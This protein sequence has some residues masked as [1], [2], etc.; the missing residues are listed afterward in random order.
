MNVQ[1]PLNIWS[2]A[3]QDA[4]SCVKRTCEWLDRFFYL[5]TGFFYVALCRGASLPPPPT[6]NSA[7]CLIALA[8]HRARV[9][10]QE[11]AIHGAALPLFRSVE[12]MRSA[13]QSTSPGNLLPLNSFGFLPT[14]STSYLAELLPTCYLNDV[15]SLGA[16][17]AYLI[18]IRRLLC[19]LVEQANSAIDSPPIHAFLLLHIHRALV[20]AHNLL[21]KIP[22]ALDGI[23]DADKL[24]DRL[25]T[26]IQP[27]K[28]DALRSEFDRLVRGNIQPQLNNDLL[29][30]VRECLT[31]SERLA[32]TAVLT[33]LARFKR[34]G[35]HLSDPAALAFG[36]MVIAEG[37]NEQDRDV[38]D[39]GIA[40]L[41]AM[42]SNGL[43]APGRPFYSDEKGRALLVPSM[44]TSSALISIC[45]ESNLS[46]S[47]DVLEQVAK[48]T[49]ETQRHLIRE[50]NRVRVGATE[51]EGWCSDRAITPD[52]VESW[53]TAGAL[54]FFVNRVRLLR[55]LKRRRVFAQYISEAQESVKPRWDK[56][57]DPDEGHCTST[58][59]LKIETVLSERNDGVAPVF[60]LYGPP[61]TSK[62]TVA[63]SAATKVGWDLLL[64]SPSD[65]VSD[66][67]DLMEQHS[68]RVFDD[69]MNVDSCVIVFDEVDI[70]FRD[71]QVLRTRLPGSILE[72]VVPALL[73]KLQ[74]FRDYSVSRNV[75]IFFLT[76]YFEMIDP[77]ISRGGRID[78]KIIVLPYSRPARK[79]IAE[80][81]YKEAR[82]RLDVKGAGEFDKLSKI[83]DD[84]PCNLGY[85]DIE[86]LVRSAAKSGVNADAIHQRAAE[87][88]VRPEAYKVVDRIGA[89][90]EFCQFF[91]RLVSEPIAAAD[92][93]NKDALI[94]LLKRG[95]R[96]V[97]GRELFDEWSKL[98]EEWE[99]ELHKK[100]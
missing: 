26:S 4:Q 76:N 63:K 86:G 93:S 81:L 69:L 90:Q 92:L 39:Q 24:W 44:E 31:I 67:L 61:G 94:N 32:S 12:T 58:L 30:I 36:L 59:K 45:L 79:R 56:F 48:G 87:T 83:L 64:L 68:R 52:R 37:F 75:V 99:E 19:E 41:T 60:L 40:T 10:L 66:S 84:L 27:P 43:F 71:R 22:N 14:F 95:R 54:E 2:A 29:P 80:D 5:Q 73:P 6:A 9:I 72:F 28:Q 82:A 38:V 13:V 78:H 23:R 74:N 21:E 70:L 20:E 3:E 34:S 16:N 42:M 57:Q 85:R 89:G 17:P 88:G 100:H 91:S 96:T 47:D 98:A 53:V 33:E 62:T 35:I 50:H 55:L 8:L 15:R 49:D 1:N 11:K 46:L 7:T 77:A 18:A 51:F 25:A 65:F 97:K